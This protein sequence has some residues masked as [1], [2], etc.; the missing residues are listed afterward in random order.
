MTGLQS[1]RCH[2]YIGKNCVKITYNFFP[3]TH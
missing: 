2:P 1:S 3:I